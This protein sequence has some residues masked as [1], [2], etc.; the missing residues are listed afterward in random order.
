MR[1]QGRPLIPGGVV[2]PGGDIVALEAGD[3]DGR[4]GADADALRERGIIGDDLVEHRLVIADQVHLVDGQHDVADADQVG[5]IAVAPR[6]GQYALARVDQ[7]DGQVGGGGAG[8]HVAGILFMAGRIG[9]DELALLGGEE[10]IGDV[11]GDALF[12]LGGEAI[13]QQGE[14][15]LAALRA[16]ALAIGLQRFE[17]ILEDHL[18][19]IEQSP[20]QGGLAV[21][22]AAAGD[23]AQH[24]LVLMDVEIGVDV[25]RDE[26]IGLVDGVL[27]DHVGHQK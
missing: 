13:D 24:G 11:D 25:L 3:G 16:D 6:L 26:G 14:V 4:E 8:D 20:D 21:I 19:I 27:C 1:H 23:E 10:A 15:D 12:A 22:D 9:D 5:E 18:R 17:L 7:D 2:G